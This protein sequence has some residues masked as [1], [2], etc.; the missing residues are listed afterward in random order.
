MPL[1]ATVAFPIPSFT[2]QK[3]P[4]AELVKFCI[5]NDTFP[6]PPN[7][8]LNSPAAPI[9]PFPDARNVTAPGIKYLMRSFPFTV[10]LP[11]ILIETAALE[12]SRNV[13]QPVPTVKFP[14]IVLV[15]P[16]P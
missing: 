4:P 8:P 11:P 12:E 9:L 13:W 3:V 1:I 7:V 15:T 16:K 2:A 10:R 5:V 6:L 14:A